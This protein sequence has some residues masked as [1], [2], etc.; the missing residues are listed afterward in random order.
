[1]K[2]LVHIALAAVCAVAL[3]AVIAALIFAV[4]AKKK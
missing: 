3:C 2:R 1:M 4:K